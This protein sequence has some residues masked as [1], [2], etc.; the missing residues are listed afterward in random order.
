MNPNPTGQQVFQL[1]IRLVDVEPL[2]WRRLLVPG[3][4]RLDKFHRILQAA[5][6]WQDYHLHSFDVG[7]ALFG[8]HI[9]DYPEEELDEK[10]MTLDQAAKARSLSYEYDFGDGWAHEVSIEKTWDASSALKF[11]VCL[12]GGGACPPEDCGGPGVYAD[13]LEVL[14]D[15]T[16]A[17]YEHMIDWAGGHIDPE[18]FDVALVNARL[19]AVR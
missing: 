18:E 2:V 3:V 4:V 15:P 16:H 17:E 9:D 6:G 11:A 19:Q 10:T 13:L 8:T 5:M 7:G 14:S 1:R 12:D